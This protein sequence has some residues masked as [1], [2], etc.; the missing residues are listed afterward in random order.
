[1]TA[2]HDSFSVHADRLDR[3]IDKITDQPIIL[4]LHRTEAG[5]YSVTDQNGRLYFPPTPNAATCLRFM[6]TFVA[7]TPGA[8]IDNASVE[9]ATWTLA[10]TL[11]RSGGGEPGAGT[12]GNGAALAPPEVLD[13]VIPIG[14]KTA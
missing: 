13:N 6:Q 9:T 5:W 4:T 10:R 14:R 2:W 3:L 7:R 1:M 8:S 11:T 12:D